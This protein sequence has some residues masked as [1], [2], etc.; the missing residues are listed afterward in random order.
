MSFSDTK[1]YPILKNRCP[2]CIEGPYFVGNNP[3][4]LRNFATAHRSCPNCHLDYRQEPGFYFGATYVSYGIQVATVLISY[5]VFEMWL[6]WETWQFATAV[7]VILLL[8]VPLTYRVSRL[9]WLTMFGE[10]KREKKA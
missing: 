6:G 2:R 7:G 10:Y 3:Y 4:N 1:L 5:A 9:T 8:M